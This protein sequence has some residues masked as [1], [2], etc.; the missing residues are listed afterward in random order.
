MT[1]S[2]DIDPPLENVLLDPSGLFSHDEPRDGEEAKAEPA[3]WDSL[4]PVSESESQALAELSRLGFS[5]KKVLE[6]LRDCSGN[7]FAARSML[8]QELRDLQEAKLMDDVA[9]SSEATGANDRRRA[10]QDESLRLNYSDVLADGSFDRSMFLDKQLGLA[11]F[12]KA[13]EVEVD[14][15]FDLSQAD[16]REQ[17]IKLLV[18]EGKAIKWYG[19]NA[20]PYMYQLIGRLKDSFS[21]GTVEEEILRLNQVLFSLPEKSGDMPVEFLSALAEMPLAKLKTMCSTAFLAT[22]S[23]ENIVTDG[24]AGEVE[25]L[26]GSRERTAPSAQVI[27]LT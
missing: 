24:A 18:L 8:T 10:D 15:V 26:A 13:M 7:H 22:A 11:A 3:T 1:Y 12:R 23:L 5:R 20:C 25:Y 6:T 16:L 21:E 17:C 4:Q 19:L 14:G 27:D 9:L 2:Y